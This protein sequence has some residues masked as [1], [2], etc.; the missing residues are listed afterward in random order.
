LVGIETGQGISRVS[1]AEHF[2]GIGGDEPWF[3]GDDDGAD[4]L[5]PGPFMMVNS[6]KALGILG[7]AAQK[8]PMTLRSAG[9][10]GERRI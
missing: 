1:Y 2:T 8:S 6:L 3:S 4:G 5:G 9:A 7:A 10:I